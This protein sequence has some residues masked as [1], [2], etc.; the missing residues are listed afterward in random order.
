MFDWENSGPAALDLVSPL[1]AGV[2]A[3]QKQQEMSDTAKYRQQ[4]IG[5]QAQ[6]E[7]DMRTRLGMEQQQQDFAHQVWNSQADMRSNQLQLG[8]AQLAAATRTNTNAT[9]DQ[10]Q[11][12]QTQEKISA[13][14]AK[15]DFD[16]IGSMTPDG[17]TTPEGVSQFHNLVAQGLQTI[18]G[19]KFVATQNQN[20]TTLLKAQQLGIQPVTG[21]DGKPDFTA[22]N[23]AIAA[24]TV[25]MAKQEALASPSVVAENVR[26]ASNEKIMAGKTDTSAGNNRV[27]N[28]Q[29]VLDSAR[30]NFQK[31][32]AAGL[33]T[34]PYLS[35]MQQ[36][37]SDYQA[38]QS[39]GGSG[40]PMSSPTP[41]APVIPPA[42]KA[43]SY[44]NSLFATPG[45][46]G[47]Q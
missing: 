43:S 27:T 5:L 40:A 22:T 44:I 13:L 10:Q 30:T 35:A 33:D 42:V 16:A 11:L 45:Q 39:G 4:E 17:L 41:S 3:G 19:Q 23:A 20:V 15:G 47:G 26:A 32:Q 12:L 28:A 2:S 7:A 31:A 46:R 36:A 14:A 8:Q 38:A 29:K 9:T 21:P 34:T 18:S 37:Q 1:A 25:D 24:K 6:Q